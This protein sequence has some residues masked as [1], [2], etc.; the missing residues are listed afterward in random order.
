MSPY[1]LT[2][3]QGPLVDSRSLTRNIGHSKEL[4]H[5]DERTF[6][7]IICKYPDLIEDKLSLKGR[8]VVVKGKRVDVLFE[9][10]HGQKL[11]VEIKKGTVRRDDVAQLLD[12]E[13]Y[14]VSPD[15]PNVRVMLVGNRV[16]ENLRRSLDHHGFEWRELTTTFLVNFLRQKCDLDLLNRLT[17]EKPLM[18]DTHRAETVL[19]RNSEAFVH[20]ASGGYTST[21]ASPAASPSQDAVER[22]VAR[23]REEYLEDPSFHLVRRQ[24]EAKAKEMLDTMLG[25]MSKVD[26]RSFLDYVN[27]ESIK[28]RTGLTRFQRHFTN[29]LAPQICEYPHEFNEWVGV[30]WR[31]GEDGLQD[32]LASFLTNA[33]IKG[34]GT[35]LPTF[36]LYLRK[37][38][39]FNI[40]TKKLGDNLAGAFPDYQP[41][42]KSQHVRYVHFNHGVFNLLVRPFSLKPE[43]VD[44][45]L[46]QLPTY[47]TE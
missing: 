11:I 8:Q 29:I 24:A 7:D 19:K 44:L 6:E 16:P 23:I 4:M 34:A 21:S 12:Y 2:A 39:A 45:V 26:I 36:V 30:L 18:H 33:P 42:G 28:G 15:D 25:S 20:R 1:P 46:S 13:G 22:A 9:D 17:P 38:T 41:S 27:T 40:Y 3:V 37:P 32:A 5:M 14:F 35:L 31:T 43:E 47:L 10:R